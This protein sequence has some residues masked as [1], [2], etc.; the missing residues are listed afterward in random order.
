MKKIKDTL[1]DS[2]VIILLSMISLI[3]I[4]FMIFQFALLIIP[5]FILGLIFHK[6]FSGVL[7]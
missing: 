2:I 5:I 7:K 3:I 6:K 1:I 4:F